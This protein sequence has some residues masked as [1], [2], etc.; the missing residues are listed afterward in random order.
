METISWHHYLRFQNCAVQ[1]RRKREICEL[2]TFIYELNSP[3]FDSNIFKA[4]INYKINC[5][6]WKG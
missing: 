6:Q 3:R 1:H 2:C 5:I 4:N